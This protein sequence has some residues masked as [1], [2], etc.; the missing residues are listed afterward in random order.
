MLRSTFQ[1][2]TAPPQALVIGA[3]TVTLVF[4]PAH[5][6]SFLHLW[7]V[8]WPNFVHLRRI[9]HI[10]VAN[11]M[12]LLVVADV[13]KGMRENC[14]NPVTVEEVVRVTEAALIE[15]Q[16][17]I[18]VSF[19][20]AAC[21]PSTVSPPSRGTTFHLGEVFRRTCCSVPAE[22]A[23]P[24]LE[25]RWEAMLS[26]ATAQQLEA[27]LLDEW[28]AISSA[29]TGKVLCANRR[30]GVFTTMQPASELPSAADE[31]HA[32]ERRGALALAAQVK[33]SRQT[34]SIRSADH[35]T[36]AAEYFK[37]LECIV[38]ECRGRRSRPQILQDDVRHQRA[39][40]HHLRDEVEGLRAAV[41]A[42]QSNAL[43]TA[44]KHEA[45]R[46]ICRFL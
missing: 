27:Q 28:A 8:W 25:S 20:G 44:S 6:L 35:I 21:L 23:I 45:T 36:G 4:S 42:L 13:Q 38:R 19:R 17:I 39:A 15:P 12:E 32:I 3:D 2:L 26:E 22:D 10:L 29:Q 46:A 14:I 1:V 41:A 5:P 33:G 31:S 30:T 7:E 34:R 9:P 16:N 40:E 24:S 43:N 18:P 11:H 37:D